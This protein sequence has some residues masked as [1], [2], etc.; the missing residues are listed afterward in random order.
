PFRRHVREGGRRDRERH[1]ERGR[2]R[3][4]GRLVHPGGEVNVKFTGVNLRRALLFLVSMTSFA[5]A[6]TRRPPLDSAAISNIARLLLLE[7]VRRLDTVELARLL[8]SKHPEV[9]RRAML[10][11]AHINDK[12]GVALL[13]A[14]PLDADTALAATA[15][16][17]V[18]QL[19]D[20]LTIPWFDSLLAN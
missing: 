8:V 15:V 6:Q 3:T 7:D 9:R 12:R 13:R 11:V 20:T 18:G 19:R 17:A 2:R 16:F 14:R 4:I 5:G 10:A 1:V